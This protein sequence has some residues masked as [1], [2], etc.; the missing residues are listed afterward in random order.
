M[1]QRTSLCEALYKLLDTRGYV[2][3]KAPPQSGK[4]AVLQLYAGYIAERGGASIYINA[5]TVSGSFD[6]EF[7][8]ILGGTL[9]ELVEGRCVAQ[10]ICM[11]LAQPALR[12]AM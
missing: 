7:A 3:I 12:S 10:G 8:R 9:Q 6:S 2:L 1:T 4:T 5:S 11:H